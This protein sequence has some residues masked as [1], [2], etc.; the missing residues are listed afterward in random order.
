[1]SWDSRVI[2]IRVICNTAKNEFVVDV[3]IG[4]NGKW[5]NLS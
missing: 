2:I 5:K 1:V 4:K 3:S